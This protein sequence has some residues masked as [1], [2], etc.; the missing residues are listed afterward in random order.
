MARYGSSRSPYMR[1]L[2][3]RWSRSRIGSAASAATP[4]ASSEVA[5]DPRE[6]TR[7]PMSAAVA[8]YTVITVAVSPP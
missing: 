2:T 3:A 8:T 5:N 7:L 1:R 4:V 6:G